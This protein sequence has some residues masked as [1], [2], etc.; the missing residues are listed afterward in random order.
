MA[1]ASEQPQKQ[2]TTAI[3]PTGMP[4]LDEQL[5]VH[6]GTEQSVKSTNK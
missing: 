4:Q 5:T 3:W 1:A 2:L 6:S